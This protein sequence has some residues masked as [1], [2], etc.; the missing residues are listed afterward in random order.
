MEEAKRQLRMSVAKC[1]EDAVSLQRALGVC[2]A[3][4]E[5]D[6]IRVAEEANQARIAAANAVA[7]MAAARALADSA[8]ER[9]KR[10]EEEAR[11]S[12]EMQGV[13]QEVA[14]S[15]KDQLASTVIGADEATR[16][17]QVMV[18]SALDP[19]PSILQPG[20]PLGHGERGRE[21]PP[22]GDSVWAQ[23]ASTRS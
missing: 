14:D 21:G 20:E 23:T 18:L 13:L 17:L 10:A 22:F 6:M 3:H 16:A 1:D 19:R 2:M 4:Q 7:E 15:M 5:V 9:A 12:K 8:K 11:A